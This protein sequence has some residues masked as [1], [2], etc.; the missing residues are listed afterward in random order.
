MHRILYVLVGV[1]VAI[2]VLLGAWAS[3]GWES[4]ARFWF[5]DPAAMTNAGT[6]VIGLV[7]GIA[8]LFYAALQAFAVRQIR[9]D[10]ETGFPILI[11]FGGYLVVSAFI[12]F[13]VAHAQGGLKF[14]GIE[15]LLVD[16]LRGAL[17]ATFAVL[18]MK[19][20]ASV[21]EIKLPSAQ[22]R[23]RVRQPRERGEERERRRPGR[24]SSSDSSRGGERRRQGASRGAGDRGGR[25]GR[26]RGRSSGSRD[27]DRSGSS[28]PAA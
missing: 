10:D 16:G 27:G 14:G 21:R 25:G 5:R 19:E 8:L 17:L 12:T 24:R 7:L 23:A 9:S 15:F 26:R 2:D 1:S 18:A 22:E 28:A 3:I 11:G 20:P 13:A 6:Q 4:F